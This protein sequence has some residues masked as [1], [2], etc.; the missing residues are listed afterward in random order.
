M[1]SWPRRGNGHQAGEGIENLTSVELVSL[2]P[3]GH[4]INM[5]AAIVRRSVGTSCT[6]CQGR[7]AAGR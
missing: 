6:K 3:Q 1:T 2:K 4:W 5:P 7:S